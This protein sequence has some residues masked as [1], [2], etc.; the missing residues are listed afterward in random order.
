MMNS[1]SCPASTHA[2]ACSIF[3]KGGERGVPP[4][5]IVLVAPPERAL[6][7]QL[8]KFPTAVDHVAEAL[9]PHVL[10]TY[11]FDLATAFFPRTTEN[12]SVA[13]R[14]SLTFTDRVAPVTRARLALIPT[15][16]S[17]FSFA[18]SLFA[19]DGP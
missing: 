1:T 7:L 6:A 4:S 15:A 9:E 2:R 17:V 19:T 14:T 5:A 13:L 3:R 11:L 8:L 18:A 12:R 10:C 16:L